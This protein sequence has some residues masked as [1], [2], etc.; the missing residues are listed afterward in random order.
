MSVCVYSVV[1]AVLLAD[2]D[3]NDWLIPSP[4]PNCRGIDR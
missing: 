1:Y 3:L 4:R 2:S